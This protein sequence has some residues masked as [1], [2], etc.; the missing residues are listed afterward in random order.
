MTALVLALYAEGPTDVRFLPIL[1]RRTVERLLARQ[2]RMD[3]DVLDVIVMSQDIQRRCTTQVERLVEAA[4][5]A[6]GYHGLIVHA[7]ADG[8]TRN[9]ALD[10]RL[11]PGFAAIRSVRE[12]VCMSVVPLIPI[13]MVEAWM[14]AD[15]EALRRI[16][17]ANVDARHLSR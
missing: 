1:I 16:I 14:L 7:D 6:A 11:A 8:P 5:M 17:G 9:R 15:A 3:V 2:G 13:H 10:E 4:R 12:K